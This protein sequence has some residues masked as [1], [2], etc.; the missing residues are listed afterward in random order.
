M[1]KDELKYSKA[2]VERMKEEVRNKEAIVNELKKDNK[3]GE[4]DKTITSLKNEIDGLKYSISG[5]N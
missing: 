4:Y 3:D 2:D 5:K 1:Q